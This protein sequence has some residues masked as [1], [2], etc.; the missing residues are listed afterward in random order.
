M[1]KGP[2]ELPKIEACTADTHAHLDMLDDPAGA[3]ER[4]AIAGM[5]LIIT[6]A[7]TTES[8]RGTLDG[9]DGWIAGAQERLD[10]WDIPN[11]TPPQVR[12]IVGT[13]PHNAKDHGDFEQES[14]V[15]LAADPRVV[16]IG[17]IGLDF[18][19]DHSPRDVQ[20][21]VFRRQLETAH[22]LGL[23]VVIH[24]REAHELGY[25]VLADMGIPEA[26][27]VL[28]CFTEDVG[29]MQRFVDLGCHISFA[30]PV[31]FKKAEEIRIA[32]REVPTDR[33]LVETDC[34]FLAPHPYRGKSNEPAWTLLTLSR[35]AEVRGIDA[36]E[37]A[38]ATTENA[39]RLFRI[40][41]DARP[42]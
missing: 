10:D 32:A 3:L 27:C 29:L 38:T 5:G 9:L 6:V 42:E 17:E 1:P 41:E 39:R 33:L 40:S 2:I 16:G 26:G 30:G 25:Q 37:L 8:P 15:Q 19:Y 34:P 35:I 13:H 18:H 4:A 20:E 11:G 22:A 21:E 7:D 36:V 12:I 28:H 23:P 14:L 24:L 31:T